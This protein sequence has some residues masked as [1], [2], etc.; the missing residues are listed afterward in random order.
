MQV[1]GNACNGT[2]AAS[3]ARSTAQHHAQAVPSAHGAGRAAGGH[4][5]WSEHAPMH[6][7]CQM[8]I[9]GRFMAVYTH[10]DMEPNHMYIYLSFP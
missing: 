1:Y 10:V 2:T 4:Q 9:F 8:A 7:C 6:D 3:S 5:R